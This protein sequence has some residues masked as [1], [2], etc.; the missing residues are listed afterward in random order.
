MD[1]ARILLTASTYYVMTVMVLPAIADM[2]DFRE[3]ID[4]NVKTIGNTLSWTRNLLLF[5]WGVI[6]LLIG[7]VLAS[8]WYN[9]SPYVPLVTS[10]FVIYLMGFSYSLRK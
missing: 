8:Y 4:F 3:D 7:N 9:V 5:N 10:V 6:F 2:L 1:R